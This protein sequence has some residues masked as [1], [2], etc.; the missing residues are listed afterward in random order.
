MICVYQHCDLHH[1][2][3][4]AGGMGECVRNSFDATK[5]EAAPG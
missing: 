2:R 5:P 4:M 3:P 1:F